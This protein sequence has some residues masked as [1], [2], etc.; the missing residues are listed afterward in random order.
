MPWGPSEEGTPPPTLPETP[1]GGEELG[2]A[3][4]R[5]QPCALPPEPLQLTS[6]GGLRAKHSAPGAGINGGPE[7]SRGGCVG[8]G[9]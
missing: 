1:G 9:G 8:G 6:L 3:L 5:P 7:A 2:P 4:R